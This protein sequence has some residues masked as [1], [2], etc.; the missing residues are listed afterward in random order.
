MAGHCPYCGTKQAHAARTVKVLQVT[1]D[2]TINPE[3]DIEVFECPTCNAAFTQNAT[4][5]NG[6]QQNFDNPLTSSIEKLG[7]VQHGFKQ[8]LENLRRNIN[9]LQT[10][11]S[12]VLFELETVR[13][14]SES[15]ADVLEEDVNRLRLEIQDL[16]ELL[17][18][19][20]V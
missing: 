12:E 7:K 5:Q 16:K 2:D 6:N 19:S 15:K 10:D 11:R 20:N 14:N 1:Q 9:A 18:L 13:K 4:T 3:V 17:G 8:N